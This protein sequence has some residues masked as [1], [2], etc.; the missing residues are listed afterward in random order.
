MPK[1]KSITGF[2]PGGIEKVKCC[3]KEVKKRKSSILARFSP[4]HNRLPVTGKKTETNQ[5]FGT[6]MEQWNNVEKKDLSS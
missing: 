5:T 4:R 2:T 6:T 1:Q 3:M